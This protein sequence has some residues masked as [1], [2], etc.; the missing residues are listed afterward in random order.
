MRVL[1]PLLL[2]VPS[3]ALADIAPGPDCGCATGADPVTLGVLGA[4]AAALVLARR[5]TR[6]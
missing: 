4:V 5:R 6:G 1:V 3:M 2:M